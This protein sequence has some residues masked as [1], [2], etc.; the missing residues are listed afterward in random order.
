M[1]SRSVASFGDDLV[2]G[3]DAPRVESGPVTPANNIS[4]VFGARGAKSDD[5]DEVGGVAGVEYS[6][7]FDND[8]GF[9]TGATYSRHDELLEFVDDDEDLRVWDLYAGGRYALARGP[10][11]PYV[12]AGLSILSLDGKGAD[13]GVG[14][15]AHAG[16]SWLIAD[17]FT[18]G[19]DLRAVAGSEDELKRYFQAAFLIGYSF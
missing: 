7:L 6:H 2:D 10:L 19:V 17:H 13:N 1:P 12:G 5:D 16:V 8:F 9:E 14:G 3:V 4:G 15:Y 18:I 11:T